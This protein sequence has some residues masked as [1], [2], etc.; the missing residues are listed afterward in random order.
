MAEGVRYGSKYKIKR[1]CTNIYRAY[2][3]QEL[4]LGIIDAQ[5]DVLSIQSGA[6]ER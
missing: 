5:T 4:P 2:T 3:K 1:Y 6:V